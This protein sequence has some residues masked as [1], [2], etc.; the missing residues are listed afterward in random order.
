MNASPCECISQQRICIHF[1]FHLGPEEVKSTKCS[2]IIPW[3]SLASR[4]STNWWYFWCF[5]NPQKTTTFLD[6]FFDPINKG[7][8]TKHRKSQLRKLH[9]PNHPR[10]QGAYTP[11]LRGKGGFCDY[12]DETPSKFKVNPPKL[13]L[14]GGWT[15]P[16]E[17]Y[18][19]RWESSPNFGMKIKNVWNHH[20]VLAWLVCFGTNTW[21]YIKTN[22]YTL[23][24]LTG[25]PWTKMSF[26]SGKIIFNHS[27]LPGF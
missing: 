6:V 21:Q 5:R 14:I 25:S 4:I 22:T 15:N 1:L 16:S 9:L 26:V 8:S 23:L 24:K 10:T 17:K 18:Q 13:F 27:Y 11:W 3:I 7:I 19:S 2:S 20:V 12:P